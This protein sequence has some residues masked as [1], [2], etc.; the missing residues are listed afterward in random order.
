MSRSTGLDFQICYVCGM[1][2]TKRNTA[3]IT[4]EGKMQPCCKPCHAEVSFCKM[5]RKKPVKEIRL[6]LAQL[7]RRIVVI[8]KVMERKLTGLPKAGVWRAK[9]GGK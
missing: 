4:P 9:K 1:R 2:I 6:Y 5:W 8:T 3:G 7:E